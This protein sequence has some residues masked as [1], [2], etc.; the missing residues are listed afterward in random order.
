MWQQAA[1]PDV[2]P[3]VEGDV[4]G[5]LNHDVVEVLRAV[6]FSVAKHRHAVA[7][8]VGK[9]DVAVPI[10]QHALRRGN[11][12]CALIAAGHDGTGGCRNAIG[13][14]GITC[15]SRRRYL[16]AHSGLHRIPRGSH[17]PQ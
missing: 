3:G 16:R 2:I 11:V 9:P 7:I 8:A 13:G 1:Y 12:A 14:E 17:P 5:F 4:E 6:G 15:H 10:R